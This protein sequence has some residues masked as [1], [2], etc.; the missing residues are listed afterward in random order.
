MHQALYWL[1]KIRNKCNMVRNKQ[2]SYLPEDQDFP[3]EDNRQLSHSKAEGKAKVALWHLSW[4]LRM[5]SW[6][7]M[8]KG[9]NVLS[10]IGNISKLRPVS[11]PAWELCRRGLAERGERSLK[12]WWRFLGCEWLCTPR[13]GGQR[14]HGSALDGPK[15]TC[16]YEG[17]AQCGCPSRLTGPVMGFAAGLVTTSLSWVSM[18]FLF[19][20]IIFVFFH[21]ISNYS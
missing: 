8:E 10:R 13:W 15:R 9:R 2:A 14:K 3:C 7:W 5:S 20:P 4:A 18:C 6:S 21:A 16:S 12:G 19:P 17:T 1:L 11:S